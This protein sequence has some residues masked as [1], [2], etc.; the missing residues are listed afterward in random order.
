MADTKALWKKFVDG[1]VKTKP[2]TVAIID[3]VVPHLEGTDIKIVSGWLSDTD[4]FW[5]VNHHYDAL[6]FILDRCLKDK[7]N[8]E[9]TIKQLRA[10]QKQLARNKPDPLS[11]YRTGAIGKPEDKSTPEQ[12]RKR[13]AILKQAKKDWIEVYTKTDVMK[14]SK[15]NEK[16][17]KHPSSPIR[18]PGTS[19][20]GTG[21]AIDMTGKSGDIDR[22]CKYLGASLIYKEP[23]NY[24]IEFKTGVAN[25]PVKAK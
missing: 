13:W 15:L 5:K 10:I 18:P 23:G 24:H 21:Y 16:V 7:G 4:Q 6:A 9:E 1:R 12:I 3:A 14:N 11:G 8:D 22:I 19:M 25:K 2:N 17:F 20:H